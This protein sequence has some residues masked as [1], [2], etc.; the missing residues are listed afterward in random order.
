MAFLTI[1]SDS[2]LDSS[3]PLVSYRVQGRQVA[4]MSAGGS[5]SVNNVTFADGTSITT[6]SGGSL[7]S[8][9]DAGSF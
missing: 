5:L 4:A 3:V 8:V 6:A 2:P 9:I 7:P 1:N